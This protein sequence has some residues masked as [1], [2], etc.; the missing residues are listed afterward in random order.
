MKQHILK[1][2]LV[3]SLVSFVGAV[4]VMIKQMLGSTLF[5]LSYPHTFLVFFLLFAGLMLLALYRIID[6][7]EHPK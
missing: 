2:L 3:A 7:L 5:D 6:L 4:G 1:I